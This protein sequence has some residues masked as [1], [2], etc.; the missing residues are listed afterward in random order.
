MATTL[1]TSVKKETQTSLNFVDTQVLNKSV[2]PSKCNNH[3]QSKKGFKI[4]ISSFESFSPF[5]LSVYF[6]KSNSRIKVSLK[7]NQLFRENFNSS[8]SV[9]PKIIQLI[10]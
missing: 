4:Q 8:C 10:P 6:R 1:K 2:L 7:H 9:K 3:K 5:T